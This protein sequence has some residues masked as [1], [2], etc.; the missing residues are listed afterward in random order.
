M[1][2]KLDSSCKVWDELVKIKQQNSKIWLYYAEDDLVKME[3]VIE[4]RTMSTRPSN[5][6]F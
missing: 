1:V 2:S 4:Y 5:C 3:Y 6:S